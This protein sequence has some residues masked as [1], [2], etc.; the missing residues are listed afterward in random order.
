MKKNLRFAIHGI[1]LYI[2]ISV[3]FSFMLYDYM[4]PLLEMSIS[5]VLLLIFNS[6]CF[7]NG[8]KSKEESIAGID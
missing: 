4:H 8:M 2:L 7:Y 6:Y 5:G 1:I 3:T